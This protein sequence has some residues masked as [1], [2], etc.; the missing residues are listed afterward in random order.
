MATAGQV[1]RSDDQMLS[2]RERA[3]DVGIDDSV[4][5]ITAVSIGLQNI[6]G[7]AGLLLFPALMG[8]SFHLSPSATAYLYGITFV[9]S[10]VVIVLQSVGLLRL[11]I[12]QAPFA[13]L[14]AA[15]L[16]VGHEHGLGTA[17]GSL[18]VATAI[19]CVLS[20]P[21]RRVSF[22]VYF[23]RYISLPIV[24]GVI[25]M[26]ISSQ[27]ATIV[28]PS[29]IGQPG[30]AGFPWINMLCAAIALV[31]VL[32]CMRTNRRVL[33]RGAIL[34]G[35]I[36]AAVVYSILAPTTWG[37]IR[38]ANAF[39]SPRFFPFGFGLDAVSVLIFFIA[40][41]PAISESIATYNMVATWADEPLPPE[42]IAQGIFGEVLGS[43][44]GAMFG[45]MSAM[46]YP[47]NV[48][49]LKV[50]K[51]A[52]RWVTLTTG[53]IL[54]V[55]GGF[56]YF[57]AVLVAIPQPV[58]AGATTILFG[59]LFAGGLEVLSKV[60]WDQDNLLAAGVPFIVAIGSLFTPPAV[61]AKLP[62]WLALMLGQPLVIGVVLSLVALVIINFNKS[63]SPAAVGVEL[64]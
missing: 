8:K 5:P 16:V 48:G 38:H 7:L 61:T 57:D 59:L 30:S 64:P 53:A 23:S 33:R 56:G 29:W 51:V 3:F 27:L 10:G 60:K 28:L 31:T 19:W 47:D 58:L 25:L 22:V 40:W 26:I 50:T 13:G 62:N 11:P 17:Y 12:V 20:I 1:S 6:L 36:V 63:G 9:T 46:A 54:I 35:V 44:I 49:L 4:S 43:A 45:G 14:F 24:S 32:L 37:N 52:S 18:V 34:L 39:N 42:R 21:I 15:L 41:F 2:S 55:L